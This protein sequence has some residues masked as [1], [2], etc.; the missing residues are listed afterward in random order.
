MEMLGSLSGKPAFL[1]PDTGQSPTSGE[2]TEAHSV[3]TLH[4]SFPTRSAAFLSLSEHAVIGHGKKALREV[5]DSQAL[6]RALLGDR[7][8]KK[9]S[10]WSLRTYQTSCFLELNPIR[11]DYL[12]FS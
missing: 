1:G 6:N 3:T 12:N 4:Y 9:K 7:K 8:K 10:N 5:G 2:S 11:K